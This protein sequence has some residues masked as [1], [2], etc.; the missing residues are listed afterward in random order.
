MEE[1]LR[2]F[3]DALRDCVL[4]KIPMDEDDLKTA[5]DEAKKEAIA[6]FQKK[7]VGGVAEG[8]VKELRQKMKQTYESVREENEREAANA[9]Q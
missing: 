8:Y 9:A 5:Y 4:H 6:L 1:G 2:T 7:A 3:E